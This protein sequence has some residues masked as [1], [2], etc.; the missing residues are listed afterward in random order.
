MS[1]EAVTESQWF[2][3]TPSSAREVREFLAASVSRDREEMAM[4]ELAVSELATNAI[5]HARGRFEVRID[6]GPHQIYVAIE[7][8]SPTLPVRRDFDTVS[9]TGRGMGIVDQVA[10]SWGSEATDYGK[11]VWF[12]APMPGFTEASGSSE[13]ATEPARHD[14]LI[15][16]DLLGLPVQVHQ[17]ATEHQLALQR[18]FDIL[19]AGEDL[20]TVPN[21]LAAL[22]EELIADYGGL[23][24]QPAAEIDAAAAR[25]DE[26]VDLR[27]IVPY[28]AAEASQRLGEILDEA[29]E[30]C[31]SGDELLTLATP[32]VFV[33]YRRW[34][35]DQFIAQADGADAMPWSGPLRVAPSDLPDT[36][37]EPRPAVALRSDDAP[38]L[39]DRWRVTEGSDDST[40]SISG[41]LDL[42]TA[43]ALRDAVQHLHN[44][45]RV[46]L[47]IDLADATFIDSV[48]LSVLVTA[49]RR[50]TRAGGGLTVRVPA[51]LRAVFDMSGLVE[52]LDVTSVSGG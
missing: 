44:R 45:G 6:S 13:D 1:G 32:P 30:F 2:D 12:E 47:V 46:D 43:P 34:F 35:L 25:G 29:D 38:E 3:A 37:Q 36:N 26:V 40:V 24:Q 17:R 11:V 14:E 8:P 33:E 5:L 41:D 31:R 16:V 22:I 23:D 19:R 18:E 52:V 48:G 7:D 21:R 28:E 39:P 50:L 9:V 51:A 15:A 10:S 42:E 4:I 27:Y 20:S 49:Q